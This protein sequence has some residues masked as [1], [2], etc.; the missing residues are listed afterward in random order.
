MD[1]QK[2]LPLPENELPKP[3]QDLPLP[4]KELESG[5]RS[6]TSTKKPKKIKSKWIIAAIILILVILLA[7]AGGYF[8]LGRNNS[9]ADLPTAP[10]EEQ[11]FCTQEAMLCPD[12]ETYVSRQGPSCEFAACPAVQAEV[13]PEITP[14]E[15]EANTPIITDEPLP[16]QAPVEI[17]P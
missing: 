4:E 8:V 2:N 10:E 5:A 15:D 13:T 1:N 14:V 7:G 11:V 17:T 16:T 12:G 9:E 6:S 3:E